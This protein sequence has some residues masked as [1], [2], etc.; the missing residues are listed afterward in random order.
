[1]RSSVHL[2]AWEPCYHEYMNHEVAAIM[3]LTII[4]CLAAPPYQGTIIARPPGRQTA[5]IIV[6]VSRGVDDYHDVVVLQLQIRYQRRQR[7]ASESMRHR[8]HELEI[9][10]ANVPSYRLA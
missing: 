6:C 10:S 4:K 2:N 3:V 9:T 5:C 1:M 7:T 8:W